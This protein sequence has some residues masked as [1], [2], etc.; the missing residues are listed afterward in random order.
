MLPSTPNEPKPGFA[1]YNSLASSLSRP[2]LEAYRI[3]GDG[4]L[5]L[6]ARYNWNVCLCEALYPTLQNLEVALRNNLHDALVGKF[7]EY[8]MWND[9][10]LSRDDDRAQVE[11]AEDNLM[12]KG[13]PAEPSRMVA[14]L[15]FGFWTRLLD[16]RFERVLWPQLIRQAFPHAP[17]KMRRRDIIS[18]RF[19]KARR[20][21]NRIFHHEP[22][23][24][25]DLLDEHRNLREILSWLAPELEELTYSYDRFS[26]IHSK[27]FLDQLKTSVQT[28]SLALHL[29]VQQPPAGQRDEI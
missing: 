13:K 25:L 23:W 24:K 4:E 28:Q 6:L 26:Q 16:R 2:R 22:V 27:A 5:D 15:T 29:R 12:A 8:W 9:P 19:E 11:K 14:E 10:P 3:K 7:G 21:R 1:L 18:S 20:L 17:A